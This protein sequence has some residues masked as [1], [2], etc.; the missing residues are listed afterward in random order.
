MEDLDADVGKAASETT[1]SSSEDEKPVEGI[2]REAKRPDRGGSSKYSDGAD[3]VS[4]TS[5][6][7]ILDIDNITSISSPAPS[8]HQ[9]SSPRFGRDDSDND[10]ADTDSPA[11]RRREKK[12]K[13]TKKARKSKSRDELPPFRISSEE[14]RPFV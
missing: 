10:T 3:A 1:S 5:Q 7:K 9:T 11:K 2:K 14:E 8:E 12:A 4:A 6:P 13:A